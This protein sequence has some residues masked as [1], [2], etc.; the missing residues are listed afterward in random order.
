MKVR[1]PTPS[2]F[3][4]RTTRSSRTRRQFSGNCPARSLR[5]GFFVAHGGGDTIEVWLQSAESFLHRHVCAVTEVANGGSDAVGV[6][7]GQL[8][9]DK[10][11]HWGIGLKSQQGPECFEGSAGDPC[12]PGA[13]PT[14]HSRQTGSCKEHVNPLP[15]IDG[16]RFVDEV[17][18]A[19]WLSG[20]SQGFFGGQ[21]CGCC[22]FDVGD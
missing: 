10:P 14:L 11:G 9:G 22:V 13:D 17:R 2:T 3:C 21:V 19:G 1:S 16:F 7:A 4:R 6:G 20:G 5:C 15:E 8:C 18:V 12:C